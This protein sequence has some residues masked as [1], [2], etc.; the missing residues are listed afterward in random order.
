MGDTDPENDGDPSTTKPH[1]IQQR[2][3]M[4]STTL[5]WKRNGRRRTNQRVTTNKTTTTFNINKIEPKLCVE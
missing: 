4:N 2:R 3:D 5:K 1:S